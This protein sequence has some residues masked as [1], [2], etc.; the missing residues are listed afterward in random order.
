MWRHVAQS[1]QGPSH[2]SDGTPCQDSHLVRVLSNSADDGDAAQTII[3]CV[4]DG[5]GSAKFSEIGSALVCESIA[6][7]AEAHL[8]THG[9]FAK[10]QLDTVLN[11]CE[12]SRNKV[13]ATADSRGC[14]LRDM[15]TTLC[16]AILTPHGSVFFQIG[17]GAITVGNNGV[18]GVVFWPQSGEYANVTNFVTSDQFRNEIE[19][20]A[21][22]SKFTEIALFTDGIERLALNFEQQTPH[23]PFFQP[24]FQAVRASDGAD[25]LEAD[26]GNFLQSDSVNNRSDDDKTLVLA[27]QIAAPPQEELADAA[28]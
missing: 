10:L 3:A 25:S 16:A 8:E 27:T 17:D 13:R 6:D 11:W 21:T 14:Q 24:L 5:A 18:Y 1:L 20:Q 22:T 26:L 4:A 15:A 2:Q 7:C 12:S 23:L 28:R 19:F 9:N